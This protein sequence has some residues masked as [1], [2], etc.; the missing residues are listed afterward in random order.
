MPL[1]FP[2]RSFL[3][4]FGGLAAAGRPPARAAAQTAA[5]EKLLNDGKERFLKRIQAVN[6]SEWNLRIN[7]FP[8]TIG[9]EAEHVALSENDLQRVVEEALLQGP[10][11]TLAEPLKGKEEMLREF[12]ADS[13]AENYRP[14]KTLINIPEVLEYYGKAN[15][16]LMKLL[17]RSDDLDETVYEHP[18][19]EIGYL[20]GR[21]WFYYIAYHRLR[22]IEQIEAV[23]SHEDF[24]RRIL[25]A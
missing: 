20:T 14:Q 7:Q 19:D 9:E 8:H 16:S 3:I 25:S 18:N 5:V 23:M 2:R 21:Q 12:F 4:A 13:A 15:R 11:P 10:R 1:H 6:N 22:H 24:P 17:V